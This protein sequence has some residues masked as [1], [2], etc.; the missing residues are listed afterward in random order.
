MSTVEEPNEQLYA[1]H[2]KLETTWFQPKP[3]REPESINLVNITLRSYPAQW[4]P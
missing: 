1:H 2:L 3:E 4:Q